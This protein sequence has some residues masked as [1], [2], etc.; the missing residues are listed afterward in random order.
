[1][2]ACRTTSANRATILCAAFRRRSGRCCGSPG[3]AGQYRRRQ[4][5]RRTRPCQ[6]I[7]AEACADEPKGRRLNAGA[8]NR[9]WSSRSVSPQQV[10]PTSGP[11]TIITLEPGRIAPGDLV[12]SA[13]SVMMNQEDTPVGGH[14]S[15]VRVIWCRAEYRAGLR[16]AAVGNMTSAL[17]SSLQVL[18]RLVPGA[19]PEAADRSR[20][21]GAARPPTRYAP[22]APLSATLGYRRQFWRLYYQVPGGRLFGGYVPAGTR[23]ELGAETPGRA[24]S[25]SSQGVS[26][27]ALSPM[28]SIRCMGRCEEGERVHP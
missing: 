12:A 1:M 18:L 26:S 4:A 14:R 22:P 28:E 13:P 11:V 19:Q 27:G 6:A 8:H 20:Q 2:S 21:A 7:A 23:A 16:A 25:L 3:P 15:G 9:C 17:A 5:S 10:L 24:A